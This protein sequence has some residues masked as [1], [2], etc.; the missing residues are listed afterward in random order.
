MTRID[1]IPHASSSANSHNNGQK[2]ISISPTNSTNPVKESGLANDENTKVPLDYEQPG[3]GE[4]TIVDKTTETT[5]GETIGQGLANPMNKESGNSMNSMKE[6]GRANDENINVPPGSV[7][8]TVVDKMTESAKEE[9]TG[10]GL[11]R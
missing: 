6:S 3:S 2:I 1:S 4:E 10:Q 7:K 11:A 5:E 8:E 9:T